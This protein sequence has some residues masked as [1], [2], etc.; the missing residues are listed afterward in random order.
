MRFNMNFW[1][2]FCDQL[3]IKLE[4]LGEIFEGGVSLS[5]I[6]A[7]IF[8]GLV[9]FDRENNKKIFILLLMIK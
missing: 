3:G 8:S 4:Q 1:A 5:D 7:L 9:T 6:R 2:E